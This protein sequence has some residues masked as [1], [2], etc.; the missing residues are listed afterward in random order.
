MS[1]PEAS[2]VA[3]AMRELWPNGWHAIDDEIVATVLDKFAAEL[4]QEDKREGALLR[5]QAMNEAEKL[6][7]ERG[8]VRALERVRDG[9]VANPPS[10]KCD[11]GDSGVCQPGCP[12]YE[13]K[14]LHKNATSA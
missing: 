8:Y 5:L 7:Y 4:I 1:S 10:P 2:A 3:V 12:R 6:G 14:L 13:Q 9:E 11:C